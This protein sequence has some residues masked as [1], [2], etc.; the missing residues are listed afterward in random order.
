MEVRNVRAKLW[1]RNGFKDSVWRVIS[2]EAIPED[3]KVKETVRGQMQRLHLG[4]GRMIC[5]VKEETF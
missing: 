5:E 4:R 2:V 3:N 1:K